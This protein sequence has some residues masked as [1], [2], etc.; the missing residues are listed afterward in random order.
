MAGDVMITGPIKPRCA[1]AMLGVV[2]GA[3]LPA[4]AH[5]LGPSA[6]FVAPGASDVAHWG[7]AAAV[8]DASGQGLSAVR[9]GPK[10]GAVI[11]GRWVDQGGQVRGARLE[12]VRLDEAVLRYPDGHSEIIKMYPSS[13]VRA[14]P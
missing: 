12:Q 7:G 2:G 6:P 5:A 14:T 9:L 8:D 11:D 4:A 3:L 1:L 10:S 13:E